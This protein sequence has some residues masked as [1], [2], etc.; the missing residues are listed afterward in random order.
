MNK[1]TSI[2]SA[3]TSLRLLLLPFLLLFLNNGNSTLFFI[4]LSLNPI[5]NSEINYD[6]LSISIEYLPGFKIKVLEFVVQIH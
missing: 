5:I 6:D 2:P 4:L 3:I 1:T